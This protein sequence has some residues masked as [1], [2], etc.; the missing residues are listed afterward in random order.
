MRTIYFLL[1]ILISTHSWAGMLDMQ[2][3]KNLN[4]N[5]QAEVLIAYKEFISLQSELE[6]AEKVSSLNIG[7]ITEAY[8]SEIYNCFYAGWPSVK[9][10]VAS[11]GK[12]KFQCS[13]PGNSNQSYQRLAS[14][15]S[16]NQLLCNPTL[17]GKGLC[18]STSTQVLRNQAFS[19]CEQK[20][21][22]QGGD[23]KKIARELSAGEGSVE[24][25]EMFRLVDDICGK[26]FQS[27][28][29]MCQNL[30]RKIAVIKK[31]IKEDS[32]ISGPKATQTTSP[33]KP[34]DQIVVMQEGVR[35]P[36]SVRRDTLITAVNQATIA[37]E[38]VRHTHGPDCGHD[39]PE[40]NRPEAPARNNAP[41][42][43]DRITCRPP[44]ARSTTKTQAEL[45]QIIKD[46]NIILVTPISNPQYLWDFVGQLERFPL[47]LRQEMKDKGIEIRLMEG[48]G[49]TVDPT[50]KLAGVREGKAGRL[51]DDVPGSGGNPTRVVVNQL[52]NNHGSINIFLHEHAHTLDLGKRRTPLN[53]S[54][55]FRAFRTQEPKYNEFLRKLCPQDYCAT[56]P[57]EGFAELFAYYHGCSES[58]QHLEKHMPAVASYFRNL[59][60]N[61]AGS[62]RS[63]ASGEQQ[64]APKKPKSIGKILKGIFK[65]L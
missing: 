3:F 45:D 43:L 23:I 29:S 35:L 38:A 47:N 19:Q 33:A 50:A 16:Q 37:Q 18:V 14:S 60:T 51:W 8:A 22:K 27:T 28:S 52:Y 53:Q 15:C 49:I 46:N 48:R 1:L 4:S 65:G 54:P 9:K 36:E 44:V 34:T 57:E 13:S 32:A 42:S 40:T 63:I 30:K 11:A 31:Y 24:A 17:F 61:Q 7:L 39:H 25:D 21:E 56:D 2:Q 12:S 64:A 6:L 41:D 62:E 26:G 5:Q 58:Q 59:G 55:E 10:Q 20:F